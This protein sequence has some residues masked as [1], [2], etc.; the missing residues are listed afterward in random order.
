M[1][2]IHTYYGQPSYTLK[3]TL[4]DVQISVQGGHLTAD[5]YDENGGRKKITPY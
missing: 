1:S 2:I 4:A 3:N 5:F